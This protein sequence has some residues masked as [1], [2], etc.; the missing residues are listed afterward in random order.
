MRLDNDPQLIAALEDLVRQE[1]DKDRLDAER[2]N[3]ERSLKISEARLQRAQSVAKVGNWELD[4][5]TKKV[6]ASK[7]GYGL[8]GLEE[9]L[10]LLPLEVIQTL[11]LPEYR[12]ELDSALTALIFRNQEYDINFKI[13][14]NDNN[15]ERFIHS[16]AELVYDKQRMPVKVIGVIQDITEYKKAEEEL[17]ERNLWIRDSQRVANIGSYMLNLQ[18][19]QWTGTPQLHEIFGTSNDPE[20]KTDFDG[21]ISLISEQEQE[22]MNEYMQEI[23]NERRLFAKEYHIIRRSDGN[24]RLLAGTGETTYAE[25]GTPLRMVGS[26]R[27]I[28]EEH[29]LKQKLLIA[30]TAQKVGTMAGGVVHDMKNILSPICSTPTLVYMKLDFLKDYITNNMVDLNEIL[31]KNPLIAASSFLTMLERRSEKEIAI[32]EELRRNN[33]IIE[34]SAERAR[35]LIED[36]SAITRGA[37]TFVKESINL[38]TVIGRYIQSPL[39][40][41]KLAEHPDVVVEINLENQLLNLMGD[42][43]HLE[44]ILTNIVIN[45]CDAMP[46]GGKLSIETHNIYLD[47][48]IQTKLDERIPLGEYVVM[49]IADTGSGIAPEY[50][51]KVFDAFFT[52]K[53]SGKSGTGLGLHIV[54]GKVKAHEG[55]IDISSELGIGTKFSFYFPATRVQV[56][57]SIEEMIIKGN[58]EEILVID[59][60]STLR[61]VTKNMLDLLNYSGA[62]AIHGHDALDQLSKRQG[63][64]P[65]VILLDMMMEPNFDGFNTYQEIHKQYG[66]IP[67]IITT[68]YAHTDRV[69]MVQELSGA[70]L[71]KKPYT[72][73]KLS[74]A[75]YE[76][77]NKHKK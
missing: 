48:G 26:I 53:H 20:F 27:D 29:S 51:S 11:V 72:P 65:N 21:W 15:E 68:G 25:D 58:G 50:I 40:F 32:L 37:S 36:L 67:T 2:E 61:E 77:L 76:Q 7:E 18:T 35:R 64:L 14:R 54:Y 42:G 46:N 74:R 1:I 6:W 30:E 4:L 45:A 10:E 71:L 33:Y 19:R 28:T 66:P 12:Q 70:P 24:E 3:V 13:R 16:R 57:Q 55:Y 9:T 44:G 39:Y 34:K 73:E 62:Y 60:D 31:I 47:S 41:E 56:K 75:I 43:S 5:N 63:A 38:N 22:G 23:I 59:D 49:T 8:Y 52:S 17:H 69:K